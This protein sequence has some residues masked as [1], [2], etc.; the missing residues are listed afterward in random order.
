MVIFEVVERCKLGLIIII[1]SRQ[2]SVLFAAANSTVDAH[3]I[4]RSI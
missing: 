3:L 1:A 4:R 2:R